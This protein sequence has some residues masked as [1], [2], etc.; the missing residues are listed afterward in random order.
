MDRLSVAIDASGAVV[1]EGQA[2]AHEDRQR[3][4]LIARTLAPE[5]PVEN[6]IVV[7]PP[8]SA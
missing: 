5:A 7:H 8:T 4:E 1:L 2:L 3:A 6:R